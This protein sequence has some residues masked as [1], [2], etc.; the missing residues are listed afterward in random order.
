MVFFFRYTEQSTA[1]DGGEEKSSKA[2]RI[3]A[4]QNA[5]PY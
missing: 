4:R 3:A 5:R 2:A 1:Q